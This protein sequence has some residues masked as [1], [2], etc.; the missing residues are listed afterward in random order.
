MQATCQFLSFDSV[1]FIFRWIYRSMH[2]LF[3]NEYHILIRRRFRT[4]KTEDLYRK[5]KVKKSLKRNMKDKY[6]C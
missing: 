4:K 3:R 5:Q 1:C 6:L 2:Q